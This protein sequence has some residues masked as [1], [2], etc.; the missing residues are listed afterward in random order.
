MTE[1]D[2]MRTAAM[3]SISICIVLT[4]ACD[5]LDPARPTAQPD[6][7]V[8]GN[9]I[10]VTRNP[11]DP[12]LWTAVIRV[13]PPRALRAAEEETGNPTPAVEK[14]LI[15]TVT[16]GP[17]AIV[18]ANDGP[19]DLE[20]IASGTEV[21]VLPVPGTT[22]IRG[23]SELWVEADTLMDFSTYSRWMLPKL[24]E[25]TAPDLDDPLVINSSGSELA[26]VPV[27]GGNV[28]YFSAHLR[29]PATA[30][31][32]WHGARRDG[33]AAQGEAI[34]GNERSYRTAVGNDGWS[35]PE[36]VMFPGLEDAVQQRVTWVSEDETVCLVTVA[37]NSEPPWVGVARRSNAAA[38]WGEV[39]PI[40]GVGGQSHDAVYLTGSRTK[41][42]F[43]S[44]RGGRDRDD[45]FLFD[46]DVETG[47][48][49]L[50]PEI[51]TFGNEWNPRTGPENELF[52][53]REDRQLLLKGGQVR[54]LRLPGSQRT[55]FTQA[56]PTADG[57]W[58]FFCMPH[59]RPLTFDEDIYVAPVG[60]DWSLG[61]PVPVDDWRP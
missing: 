36:L 61:T 35:A 26:P 28:L 51:C 40:E 30:E 22:Q 60:K 55:V 9:L 18:I 15:A 23:S 52:F 42:V 50:Q 17:D 57:K 48:L 54:A 3:I 7:E 4:G 24:V 27:A 31:D 13:G 49:P 34:G 38:Q 5:F 11:D 20:S 21:V 58:V 37:M 56:A 25:A 8:F 10:E 12:D 32:A 39:E 41:L 6:A 45:L 46:P 2:C 1:G 44:D 43:A 19:A 53:C 16:I 14:G 33:L 29:P 59:Y 47:P